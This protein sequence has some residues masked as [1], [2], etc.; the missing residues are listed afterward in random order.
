MLTRKTIFKNKF[1]CLKSECK[2]IFSM[3]LLLVFFCGFDMK[4]AFFL[5]VSKVWGKSKFMYQ[6]DAINMGQYDEWS[7]S[8]LAVSLCLIGARWRRFTSIFPF[9]GK[10]FLWLGFVTILQFFGFFLL[11]IVGITGWGIAWWAH[12]WTTTAAAATAISRRARTWRRTVTI[13]GTWWTENFTV[14]LKRSRP[15]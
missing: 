1:N 15:T 13:G 12:C 14:L 11:L 5:K 7:I 10:R 4:S 6:V 2:F 3:C 8:S 9:F